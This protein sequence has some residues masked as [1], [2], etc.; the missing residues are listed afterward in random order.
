MNN[1]EA[2]LELVRAG[3]WNGNVNVNVNGN[4]NGNGNYDGVEWE[5]VFRL[6]AEQ[7][8]VGLVAAGMDNGNVKGNFNGNGN[9]K[10]HLPFELKLGFIG[11]AL[12]I[13]QRNLAMNE[14][15]AELMGRLRKEKI[16]SLLV[17]GQGVAQCYEKPLWRT[18]GD[19]DLLM[20]EDDYHAAKAYLTPMADEVDE[21][22]IE[23][24]HLALVINGFDVELHARMPFEMS[25]RVDKVVEEVIERGINVND[26]DNG[27]GEV[28]IPRAD[29]HLI[30]VFTHFLH[31]FFIEGVG[32]RQICDWC[33]LLWR[34]RE[35]L[36]M[37]L[38]ESRI[39]RMGLMTEWKVFGTLAVNTLGIPG[40]AM[41]FYD[42]RY[43]SKGERVLKRVL[44]SGNFGHNNDLSYR[45]RYSGMVYKVVAAW[46]RFVDFA[47]LVPVFPVDAPRF[48]A[49]Y[50]M[51]KIKGAIA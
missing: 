36:D 51:N 18:S 9:G 33:R 19:I 41:P 31:H 12:Q 10:L 44:K 20:S 2:F 35:V 5:E 46:R 32:L 14:F 39:R 45:T 27:N 42:A 22:N 43:K 29:E 11:E 28:W 8:V 37:G 25:R 23:K 3:L 24:K 50:I 26:N 7:S 13:E 40:D 47:S 15:I 34:Y 6:A 48:Y 17:K 38:L 4:F 16:H 1:S 30:L 21:E 49:T